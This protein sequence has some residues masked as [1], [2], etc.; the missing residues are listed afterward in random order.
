ML[1]TLDGTAGLFRATLI[2]VGFINLCNFHRNCDRHRRGGKNAVFKLFQNL[3]S[4]SRQDLP[5]RLVGL[6][7]KGIDPTRN[8][9]Y[10]NNRNREI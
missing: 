8:M 5:V 6:Y 9:V 7:T 1:K 10:S 3:K 2:H 4:V